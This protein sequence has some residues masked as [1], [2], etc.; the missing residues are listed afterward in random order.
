VDTLSLDFYTA[1]GEVALE[2]MHLPRGYQAQ[3]LGRAVVD[4]LAALGDALGIEALI[5]MA[6]DVGRYAWARC[7]FDFMG[8]DIRHL[9]VGSAAEFA[10]ALGRPFDG[11]SI[12]HSWELAE[13][14]GEDVPL[15]QVA[16]L[17]V[18]S[19]RP[20]RP[21]TPRIAGMAGNVSISGWLATTARTGTA[22]RRSIARCAVDARSPSESTVARSHATSCSA[23]PAASTAT[24]A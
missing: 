5:T 14:A 19:R 4:E 6:A 9:V 7:G 23:T 21:T 2:D 24:Q 20:S 8:D 11:S 3:G 10:E 15:A 16:Q 18:K 17:R 13:Y 22:A 12:A 1:E